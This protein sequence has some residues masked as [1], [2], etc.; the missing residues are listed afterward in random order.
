M[1]NEIAVTNALT[2][3]PGA[4]DSRIPPT[5]DTSANTTASTVARNGFAV[6]RH[7]AAAGVIISAST[8]SAPTVCTP[9]AVATPTS[10]ANTGD[11]SPVGTPRARATSGSTDANSSGR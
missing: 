9:S 11:S 10:T 6:I 7:A 4:S 3:A 1:R 8:S 5:A 2:G